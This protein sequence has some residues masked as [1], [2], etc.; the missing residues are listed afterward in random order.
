MTDQPTPTDAVMFTLPQTPDK[1]DEQ[2]IDLVAAERS[3]SVMDRIVRNH[4]DMQIVTLGARRLR[5][6]ESPLSVWRL[7]Q[8]YVAN[9]PS[10]SGPVL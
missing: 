2:V 5:R 3:E 9:P 8:N 7:I 4:A 10:T 6:G 1:T